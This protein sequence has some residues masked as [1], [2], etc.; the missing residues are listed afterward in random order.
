[1]VY[2][3]EDEFCKRCGRPFEEQSE[4]LQIEID[5]EDAAEYIFDQLLDD[6]AVMDRKDILRLLELLNEYVEHFCS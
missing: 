3:N 4:S 6:G 2:G 5:Y 1:M